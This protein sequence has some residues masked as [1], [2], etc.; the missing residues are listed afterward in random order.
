MIEPLGLRVLVAIA[1][2]GSVTRAARDLGYSPSNVTQH[3][4]RLEAT[5]R[6]PMVE[7][8]GRG[9]VLTERAR[10]LVERGR[11]V[12]LELDDLAS[13]TAP[14][15]SGTIDVAAFPTGLRGLLIPTITALARSIPDLSVR[16]HELEPDEA[17]DRLRVGRIQAAI[18]KEWGASQLRHDEAIQQHAIG[19]DTI[20]VI[21]P[22]AHALAC[23]ESLT[24][25]DLSCEAWALTPSDDPTYRDWFASHEKVLG[26]RPLAIYEASEFASLVTFVEHNL[27]ITMIPR[28]GRGPLP[29]TVVAVPLRG[30]DAHRTISIATRRTSQSS[31][32]VTAFVSTLRNH[33]RE[34]LTS[35]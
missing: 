2:A 15:P 9:V 18:V 30:K 13:S 34:A 3:L 27:A 10:V 4:R 1:D 7:R 8:V 28:L 33:A 17:L 12:L 5:L 32:N 21:L 6:T 14:A 25:Q 16:P 29:S 19:I 23:T 24:L 31:P 20:D 35:E 26:L 22:A 11:H